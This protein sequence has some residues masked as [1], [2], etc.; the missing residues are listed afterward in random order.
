MDNQLLEKANKINRDIQIIESFLDGMT[1]DQ[2]LSLYEPQ[3]YF[4]E[5]LKNLIRPILKEY[6]EKLFCQ[7]KNL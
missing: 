6:Q 4:P 5:D 3:R 1:D 2:R 7:L